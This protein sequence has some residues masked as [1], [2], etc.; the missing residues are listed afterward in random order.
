MN[1]G[2]ITQ[3]IGPVL[4]V[5]FDVENVPGIY[6]ALEIKLG[7]DRLVAE[8]QQ[9]LGDGQVRAVSM[10]STDGV[11]R[12]ME[13]TDTG[14]PISVP[15]GVEVLGRIFNVLGEVV[16]GKPPIKVKKTLPIHRSAPKFD[17][18]STK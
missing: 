16:D 11:K 10:G 18:Q 7:K 12:G 8:V 1:K 14:A 3:I 9:H 5:Q 2:K 17:E 4:D 13:V 15:V 6:S